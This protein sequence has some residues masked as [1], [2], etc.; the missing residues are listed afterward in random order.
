MKTRP[1]RAAIASP[2]LTARDAGL[3]KGLLLAGWHQNDIAFLFGCNPGRVAEVNG[4]QTFPDT[5]PID[6]R[7]TEGANAIL[8]LYAASAERQKSLV[9]RATGLSAKFI[10]MSFPA[11][12]DEGAA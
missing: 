12:A 5:L 11:R 8:A 9:M 6:I 2:R 1:Y 10:A 3:I 4:R 7:S